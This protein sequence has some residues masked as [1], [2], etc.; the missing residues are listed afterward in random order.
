MKPRLPSADQ[1][2][3]IAV[4]VI[5]C[6]IGLCFGTYLRA[7]AGDVLAF[8]GG[9]IGA[10]ASVW[11]AFAVVSAKADSDERLALESLKVVAQDVVEEMDLLLNIRNG[12]AEY[13][14]LEELS[15]RIDSTLLTVPRIAPF[16]ARLSTSISDIRY[17]GVSM[18][19]CAALDLISP[20]FDN[21]IAERRD[22][23]S[24]MFD[25]ENVSVTLKPAAIENLR[26]TAMQALADLNR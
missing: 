5:C 11:G 2:V 16:V 4:G 22:W 23:L 17:V 9:L 1:V 20:E 26:R 6:G 18:R 12:T 13:N 19:L 8:A 21:A 10:G 15:R 7:D 24:Q 3:G 14:T 25:A